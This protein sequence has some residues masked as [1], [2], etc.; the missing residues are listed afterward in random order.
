MAR[1]HVQWLG[2]A[3][4]CAGIVPAQTLAELT[5]TLAAAATVDDAMVGDDGAKS[6]TYRAY[7]RW[8]G[9]A[10]TAEL[11]AF[12]RHESA[13]VRAYAVK[14]LVDLEATVDWPASL[15]GFLHDT[16]EVTT[17][18]GCCLAKEKVG[19]VA[20][21]LV[22]PWL[23]DEQVLDLAEVLIRGKSPLYAREWALRNLRLRDG[24]LH[25]VRD[26]ARAGDAPAGIALARYHLPVDVPVLVDLLRAPEPFDGNAP[27]L[28][29]AEHGD[30]RLLEPLLALE[31]AARR[32]IG[33]D[34]PSRLRFWLQAIAVQKSEP[35]GAFLARF[36][37]TAEPENDWKRRDLLTTMQATIAPY[38]DV[39]AFAEVRAEVARRQAARPR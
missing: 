9:R 1:W 33:V 22:R 14:A 6:D 32:R 30:A 38:A 7:E 15:Q 19:D 31:G 36:L 20:I 28:A 12:T 29:A 4:A 27:F 25:L 17:F 34:N 37:R 16:A 35:A 24:M 8:R 11:L 39:D 21:D 10:T 23:T 26:L 13:N 18:R 2:L 5:A 3:I